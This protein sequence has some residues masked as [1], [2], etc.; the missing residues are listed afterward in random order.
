MD[1][2]IPVTNDSSKLRQNCINEKF[3][4]ETFYWMLN[5]ALITLERAFSYNSIPH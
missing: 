5:F 4:G 3:D 2:L 1:L